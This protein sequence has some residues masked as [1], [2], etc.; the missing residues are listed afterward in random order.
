SSL[1]ILMQPSTTATAGIPFGQQ[2]VLQVRDQFGNLRN[3]ANGTADNST[4]VTAARGN[5]SGTLQ[6][7]LNVSAS[8]GVATFT[9]LSHNVATNITLAFSA[10][11]LAGTNSTTIAVSPAAATQLV[12]I[13]QPG[14]TTYGSALSTQP[15]LKTRD[16]FGNDSTVGLG[17]S[18]M[19]SLTVSTG[20]GS[21]L[22]STSLDIGTASGNGIVSF[23]GLQVSMAGTGKQLSASSTG[24]TSALS[25][26]FN[27]NPAIVTGSIS[28]INKIYDGTTA[29]TI[30]SRPLGGGRPGDAVSLS[31]G[32][33]TFAT[34]SVGTAKTVTA[35]GLTL[36]GAAAGNYQLASTSATALADITARPL[37]VS[38]TGVNKAYDGTTSATVTLA[39]NRL[40]GDS[41]TTTYTT[42]TFADKNLGTT[43][44][45]AVSGIS[46]TGAD[47][48]N[49]SANASASAMADITAR[50]LTITATGANKVYDGTTSATVTLSDDRLAGDSLTT[51]YTSASFATKSVATNKTVSVS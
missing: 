27:V 32:T 18:K 51:S 4:V 50:S 29:A 47:P 48:A 24:L 34:K 14:S 9:S 22:G 19:V 1:T 20:T 17:A 43:K 41:F 31:G 35:T 36:S 33:A 21:L 45:V 5:G 12:F 39:D 2:P 40:A 25:S 16:S 44:P 11:G 15:M 46:I 8:D 13:T 26:S 38:A 3:A 30:G 28:A 10:P 42:A 23:S 6:G 49:Y 7:T 37:L